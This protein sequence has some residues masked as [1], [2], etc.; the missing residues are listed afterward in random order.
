MIPRA[1]T[2][3]RNVI[4][5]V[6]A[7]CAVRVWIWFAS[8]RTVESFSESMRQVEHAQ[9]VLRAM[10][11]ARYRLEGPDRMARQSLVVLLDL[12]KDEPG[13]ESLA[14]ELAPLI[15]KRRVKE[16][17][18]RL[19]AAIETERGLL[20]ARIRAQ[21]ERTARVLKSIAGLAIGSIVI[22][23]AAA[24]WLLPAFDERAAVRDALR[25]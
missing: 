20:N 25:P 22:L 6:T 18:D 5:L 15:E 17:A 19:D 21:Q 7:A 1:A 24:C 13:Q 2:F 9:A 14:K 12:V 3:R 8:W 10:D 11:A 23:I 4:L 16:A